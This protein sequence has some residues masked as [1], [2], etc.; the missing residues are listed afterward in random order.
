MPENMNDMELSLESV[1]SEIWQ[2]RF[3]NASALTPQE[4]QAVERF[5]SLHYTNPWYLRKIPREGLAGLPA[6]GLDRAEQVRSNLKDLRYSP[7]REELPNQQPGNRTLDGAELKALRRAASRLERPEAGITFRVSQ[8]GRA[9]AT[10]P[11]GTRVLMSRA[12]STRTT[13]NRRTTTN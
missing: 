9:I 13:L 5:V 10:G 4:R 7:A 3:G 8:D 6:D 2:P 1:R 12:S 11:K